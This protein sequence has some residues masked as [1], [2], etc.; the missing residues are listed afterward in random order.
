MKSFEKIEITKELA[1]E[2]IRHLD[3]LSSLQGGVIESMPRT[4]EVAGFLQ[5]R[6]EVLKCKIILEDAA[7]NKIPTHGFA[8]PKE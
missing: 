5:D 1:L 3:A 6:E 2:I 4:S 8:E 7:I